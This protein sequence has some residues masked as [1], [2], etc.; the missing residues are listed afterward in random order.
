MKIIAGQAKGLPLLVPKGEVRPTQDRVREALFGILQSV[1]PGAH[2]L[3]LFCGTGSV[4]LEALSRGAAR[5]CM[6]DASRSACQT[7]RH[8][9]ERSKLP[10][11]S[12]VQSDC[13]AFTRRERATYDLIFADPPYC[14]APGDR[15]MIAELLLGRVRELLRENGLFIAEAQLGYG[16]GDARTREFPGWELI[17]ARSYGKNT[18]LFYR[19]ESSAS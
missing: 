10:G 3:D 19:P 18:L 8:N 6:V 5:A 7:A 14:K 11:G 2:V 17:D 13:L 12:I 16:V 9:M 4:G 1:V 15:D